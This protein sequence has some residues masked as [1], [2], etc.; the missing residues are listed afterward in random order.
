M[1]R[2]KAACLFQTICFQTKDSYPSDYNK[3]LVKKE[4]ETY[5]NQMAKRGIKFEIL[6]ESTLPDGSILVKLK[7][8]N[9]LQPVCD[10]F[11]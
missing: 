9:S 11:N 6:E 8:Q 7:K 3:Q 5:T 10:Y 4:Y 2:I 1:K